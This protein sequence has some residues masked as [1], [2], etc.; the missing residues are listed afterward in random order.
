MARGFS[1]K[2]WPWI[3]REHPDEKERYVGQ[4]HAG[5]RDVGA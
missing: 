4:G 1:R 5:E 2:R 3:E